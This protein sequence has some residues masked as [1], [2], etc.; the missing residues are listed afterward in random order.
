MKI[1]AEARFVHSRYR[2]YRVPNQYS[3]NDAE[4]L[5]S[6]GVAK[7]IEVLN[8]RELNPP[9]TLDSHGF[10]LLVEPTKLDLLDTDVVRSQYYETVSYTHLTLPTKA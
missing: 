7:W 2:G 6:L 10:Q 5:K 3:V 9:P 8:G 1:K 4:E